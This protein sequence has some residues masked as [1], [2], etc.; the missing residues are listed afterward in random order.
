MP[1]P[2]DKIIALLTDLQGCLCAQ[3]TP[4][5]AEG[6][7]LCLCIPIPGVYPGQ[8][9]AGVGQELAWARVADY[10]P[11]NTPGVQSLL[12]YNAT[13]GRTV[14]IE[15][16]V[17]RCHSVPKN[18]NYTSD[19]LLAMSTRQM[20]DIGSMERALACCTG[21]SWDANQFVVG[22]YRPIGPEGDLY[23]GAISIAMQIE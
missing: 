2:D 6:P 19:Q 1:E 5:G 3:L 17:L 12:P 9:Y 4:E 14:L 15:M 13:H 16:G 21:A 11:S 18:G 7:P 20:E 10:F 22:N 8:A 23:G